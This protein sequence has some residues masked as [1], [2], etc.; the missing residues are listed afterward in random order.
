M[1]KIKIL[2]LVSAALFLVNLA[3]ICFLIAYKPSRGKEKNPKEVIIKKLNFDGPQIKEYEKLIEWHQS[4]ILQ[5]EKNLLKLKNQLYSN[6]TK[7]I[8]ENFTDSLLTE[9]G[10]LHIDMEQINYKHFSEIKL[11]CKPEQMT[12][13]NALYADI[14]RL[15]ERKNPAG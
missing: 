4:N 5:S 2:S 12:S 10:K 6:L 9:I 7:D 3:L 1:N 15:F 11:L 8:K 14:N 13:F